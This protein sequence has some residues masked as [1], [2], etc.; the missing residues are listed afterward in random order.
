MELIDLVMLA[1]LVTAGIS[2]WRRGFAVVV[3]SYL[4]LLGG[5]ALGAWLA[6]RVG[7]ALSA[8]DSL[9]RLLIGITVF[10]LVASLCH[11]GGTR[12][13]TSLRSRLSSRFAD[14]LDNLG[15]AAVASGVVA[16]ALWFVGLTLAAGPIPEVA[17]AL[18]H[19][20]VLR[21][22]DRFTPRPPAAI[23]E[24]RRLLDRS[25]FPEAFASLR[26]PAASGP[27][28][29][30]STNPRV[31]AAA[32]A[33]VQ[34]R[35]RGCGG[36]LFG[37]GFPVAPDLIVTNAHVVAGTKDPEVLT[38]HG[39]EHDATVV[40]FDHERDIAFLRVRGAGLRPLPLADAREDAVGVVIGYPGGGEE[41]VTGARI[42]D[43]T[44]AVGRDIYSRS[45]VQREIYV[46]RARI[47]KG[48][49]G[50]PL[51][52]QA[53]QAVGVVFAASTVDRN[54]GYALTAQELR[55]ARREAG[56]ATRPVSTGS[57]AA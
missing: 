18:S 39:R 44:T 31:R 26:P 52:N 4:G 2:G 33:T 40:W 32:E 36:L 14:G 22:I 49:S 57:C 13:G 54:E 29:E 28:P 3:L 47:R 38:V 19:S 23:N 16:I 37:S 5:L 8:T 25:P 34:V 9:G 30:V 42:V 46:L 24:L 55:Q 50:G 21:T 20:E 6:A 45:L 43:R 41:Q 27:P 53:G 12:L 10:F 48:N 51:V 11:V 35:S 7:L 17:Q 1:I 15:G 56:A